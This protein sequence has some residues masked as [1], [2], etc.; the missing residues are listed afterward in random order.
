MKIAVILLAALPAFCQQQGF[1]FSTLDKLGAKAKGSTN[2]SLDGDTLKAATT[3]L[4]ADGDKDAAFLKNLKSVQVR[5]YE[6]DKEGQ[7]DPADLVAVR[8]YVKSLKWPKI[9]D[10]KEGGETTEIYAM[11]PGNNQSGGLAIVSAEAKEVSVIFIS[12]SINLSDVGKLEN[13]GIPNALG[14]HDAQKS[15]ATKKD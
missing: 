14:R 3:L 5:S 11:V 1:D 8:T 9:V 12:G 7:Y 10:V 4:G 15:E 6:F 2:I 13:L